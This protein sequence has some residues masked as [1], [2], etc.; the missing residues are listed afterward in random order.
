MYHEVENLGSAHHYPESEGVKEQPRKGV[1][2][3][4]SEN[5]MSRLGHSITRVGIYGVESTRLEVLSED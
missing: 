3:G 1:P 4:I 5:G 2:L